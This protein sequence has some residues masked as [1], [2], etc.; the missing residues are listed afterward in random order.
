MRKQGSVNRATSDSAH[1][2]SGTV[3]EHLATLGEQLQSSAPNTESILQVLDALRS[4]LRHYFLQEDD[5]QLEEAVFQ[6][7]W[8]TGFAEAL[9]HEHVDLLR[10]LETLREKAS[11]SANGSI[12]VEEAQQAHRDFVELLE[13]HD[14]GCRNLLYESQLCQGHLHD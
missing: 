9:R 14:E 10:S 7:P 13:K 12:P 4:K 5:E 8:L 11:R 2:P 3:S 1:S 6:A